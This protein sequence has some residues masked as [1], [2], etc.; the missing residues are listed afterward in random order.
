ML[1]GASVGATPYGLASAFAVPLVSENISVKAERAGV[2]GP[3]GSG[4]G[5]G[6]ASG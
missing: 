3:C 5:L 2:A 4:F 6:W 1:N